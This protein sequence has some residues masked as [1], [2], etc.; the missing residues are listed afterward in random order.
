MCSRL[1]VLN[2]DWEHVKAV[3]LLGILQSFKPSRGVIQRVTVYVSDFG[4]E[5]MAEEE[6]LGPA[7]LRD[8]TCT[9][10]T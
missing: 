5:R 3:D 10:L 1:A 8:G 4:K 2:C 9:C 7:F 6:R